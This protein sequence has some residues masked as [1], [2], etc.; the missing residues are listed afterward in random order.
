M[1]A[2]TEAGLRDPIQPW[3]EAIGSLG[4]YV[5]FRFGHLAPGSSEIRWVVLPHTRF[6]GIGG[7][8]HMLREGGADIETLPQV[9][10]P[11]DP[12]WW[13]FV[14]ALPRLLGPRRRVA[15]GDL[16]SGPAVAGG[17]LP[18]PVMA[19]RLFSEEETVAL[20]GVAREAGVTANTFLL[21]HLDDSLRPELAD[22]GASVPWMIPVNLRGKINRKRDTANHSSYIAIRIAPGQ[23]MKDLH[24]DVYRR[25]NRG[26]H[27]AAWRGYS[28]TQ[29][30]PMSWKRFLLKHDRAM[31]QWNLGLFTNLG[32]WDSEKAIN[33]GDLR[34]A[35]L[36]MATVLRC[37]MVGAACITFQGRLSITIQ[38]H[39][40]LT[41]SPA[42]PERWMQRWVGRLTA[43]LP[44]KPRCDHPIA[45]VPE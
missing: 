2:A 22:P 29:W 1:K 16:E 34:G 36:V 45:T 3:Y 13:P 37:Q 30:L 38:V 12:S 21:K 42:V 28:A 40:D 44:V 18:D 32:V 39:P 25:L 19:W 9:A 33:Q 6:D 14:R 4:D 26:E 7:F 11:S 35:W 24:R 27:W 17:S 23:G 20:R 8:A 15:W 31:T 5:T 43:D 41:T 10:H